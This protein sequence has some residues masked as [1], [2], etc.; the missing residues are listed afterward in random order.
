MFDGNILNLLDELQQ[1]LDYKIVGSKKISRIENLI[2][3]SIEV[4]EIIPTGGISDFE[5]FKKIWLKCGMNRYSDDELANYVKA[6]N[7]L[8]NS[9]IRVVEETSNKIDLFDMEEKTT[10]VLGNLADANITKDE[11]EILKKVGINNFVVV[12]KEG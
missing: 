6:V 4:L 10:Y 3:D 2:K 8:N 11:A 9:S 1:L 5:T 7:I 12:N